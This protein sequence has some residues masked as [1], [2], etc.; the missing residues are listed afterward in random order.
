M[1]GL[2]IFSDNTG[3]CHI[4]EISNKLP[5]LWRGGWL[6]IIPSDEKIGHVVIRVYGTSSD[7][8]RT[9]SLYESRLEIKTEEKS[10]LFSYD[11]KLT[12]DFTQLLMQQGEQIEVLEHLIL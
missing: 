2:L 1:Y 6:G 12:Y 9:L 3:T 7:Y 11:V 4:K 10:A 8:L 5:K